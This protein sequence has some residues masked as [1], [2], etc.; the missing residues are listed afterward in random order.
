M[1]SW[2]RWGF[3]EASKPEI[4]IW[5]GVGV[6][7]QVR[8]YSEQHGSYIPCGLPQAGTGHTPQLRSVAHVFVVS[9]DDQRLNY[10]N[11]AISNW[12]LSPVNP[13]FLIY[14]EKP[15]DV[16]E[17][18]KQL[19]QAEFWCGDYLSY[20]WKYQDDDVRRC[21]AKL[22]GTLHVMNLPYERATR[23]TDSSYVNSQWQ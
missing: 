21:F 22:T 8:V 18:W 17:R 15:R 16:A 9:C 12:T 23:P 19:F 20:H 1:D 4:I 6:I 13:P 14:V 5:H 2:P 7:D 3:P 11:Y 10:L